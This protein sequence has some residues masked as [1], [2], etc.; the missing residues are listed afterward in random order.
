MQRNRKI[1][2]LIKGAYGDANVG[3]DLLL[4]MTLDLLSHVNRNID[5]KIVCKKEKY[6]KQQ[7]SNAK[8]L[9]LAASRF[10]SADVYILGGGTQFF[11]FEKSQRDISLSSRYQL[12]FNL[13]LKEPSLLISFLTSKGKKKKDI[14][15]KLALGIGLG[16][17][18][19]EK[20]EVNVKNDLALYDKIYCR[21]SISLQYL[22][23]WDLKNRQFG[24][25]LCLTDLFKNKYPLN[26]EAT[27]EDRLKLGV[28]LRDWPHNNTGELINSKIFNW[29]P[30][31]KDF[32]R[33]LFMFSES[34]DDVL[35]QQVKKR[36]DL[37]IRNLIIWHP[38]K[39]KFVEFYVYL[40]ECDILITSRYHAAIFALNLGIPT[41]CLGIDPKLKALCDEVSGF[42][43]WNPEEEISV[44]DKYIQNIKG[45]YQQH[46]ENIRNSYKTLNA[47]ANAMVE[48]VLNVLRNFE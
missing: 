38:L 35:I 31:Q 20:D 17:F 8:F 32:E 14:K 22:E 2:I 33:N 15:L 41:I 10:E 24:A 21:D 26:H 18:G 9:S 16:P 7:F 28:V 39:Y 46:Q 37:G 27:K 3:D 13:L 5:A 34:K 30:E 43:Y 19:T 36:S 12:Y 1:D 45:N 47:R 42:Y 25:D 4:E 29:L 40:N 44:L 11:S 23:K 48:D 6:I